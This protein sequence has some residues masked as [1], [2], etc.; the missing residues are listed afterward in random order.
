M[1]R[2]APLSFTLVTVQTGV[3]MPFGF[4]FLL[5]LA[6]VTF[7]FILRSRLCVCARTYSYFLDYL[8]KGAFW[9]KTNKFLTPLVSGE[10]CDKGHFEYLV[11]MGLG[12]IGTG[13]GLAGSRVWSSDVWYVLDVF[14]ASQKW[15]AL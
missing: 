13:T 5:G 14:R 3:Y 10:A 4:T 9:L 15:L 7:L 12:I 6:Y 11:D 1:R 8:E 2:L